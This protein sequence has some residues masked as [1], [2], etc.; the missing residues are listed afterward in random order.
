M[1]MNKENES[2]NV[3]HV[4]NGKFKV[5]RLRERERERMA[6]DASA[7]DLAERVP[8]CDEREREREEE[9]PRNVWMNIS[10]KA[11]TRVQTEYSRTIDR[12]NERRT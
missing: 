3:E 12:T 2:K 10:L 9:S 6:Y 1:M 4:T 8:S 5:R 11:F 7:R